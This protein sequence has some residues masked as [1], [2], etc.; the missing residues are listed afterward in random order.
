M[1]NKSLYKHS[2]YSFF[3]N[4]LFYVSSVLTVL[5]TSFMFYFVNRFFLV[6]NSNISISA[7]FN[8]ISS[9]FILIVPLLCF[10]IK[11]FIEDDS[12]P[13]GGFCRFFTL[14]VSVFSVCL[15]PLLL[16]V[17][18]PVSVNFFGR[19]DAGQIF[20]GYLAL[21]FYTFMAI[22]FVLFLFS[23]IKIS[24]NILSLL[25]SITVLFCF[26]FVHL[27]PLYLKTGDGLSV[28]LQKMSFAWHFDAASKGILD[29]RDLAFY[30]FASVL[31]L[32]LAVFCENKRTERKISRV[33][34][35]L[36]FCSLI[37]FGISFER[38]YFRLDFTKS[39][40]FSV[41]QT[42]RKLCSQLQNPLRITYYQSKELKNF[43]PQS[44]EV[45]EYLNAF[46]S[47]SK[48]VFFSIKKA[49]PEKLERLGIQG[50]Q[51]KSENSTKVEYTTVYSAIV[52]QYLDSSSIIPFSI[53]TKTLEYDLAQRVQLLVSGK[54]RKVFI[55]TGNGFSEE[56][57]SYVQPWLNARGFLTQTIKTDE[58]SETLQKIQVQD[59]K[60]TQILVLGSDKLNEEQSQSIKTAVENGVPAL[61]MTSPYSV[62]IKDEWKVS[63]N[64]NPLLKVLNGWGFAFDFSL[65]ED[66]SNFPL[67]MTSTE[68][69]DTVYKTMNYPL[70]I[71]VLPQKEAFEGATITWASP[72]ICYGKTEPLLVSSPLAWKQKPSENSSSL[73]ILDPFV[74]PKSAAAQGEKSES[75]TLAAIL[76]DK[77]KN[78]NV[79][80]ISDQFFLNSLMTGFISNSEQG[81]FRNYD[82]TASILLKL[83]GEEKLG[84]LIQKNVSNNSLYKISDENAFIKKQ[85]LVLI[86]CF[87]VLPS[88]ILI[89]ALCFFIFRKKIN[90]IYGEKNE[91]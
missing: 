48:N 69:S 71:S 37:F 51:M 56:D 3:I 68:G 28:F 79:A 55:I 36:F 32:F 43:Y 33:T 49:E 39:R 8:S 77:G 84:L 27:I 34:A 26:N 13:V 16:L 35:S 5:Y 74:V 44:Q 87:A 62:D 21:V 10:R 17:F 59:I 14:A 52:L 11:R 2:L 31:F 25:L 9:V 72:I 61:I 40:Q 80:L 83:R 41:S 20:T 54:E 47:S 70:W 63:K 85:N 1:I 89:F 88:V 45:A 50:R 30:F 65:A 15:I 7:F 78:L 23:A 81:D 29:S 12:L 60:N 76:Q 18:I 38:I 73:F 19:I 24:Q 64:Q 6:S 57:Y 86:V 53:S 82:Y 22:C 66:I 75:L 67:T 46:A 4:P 58:I 90:S 91:K 42:S